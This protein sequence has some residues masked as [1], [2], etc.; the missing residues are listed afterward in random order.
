MPVSERYPYGILKTVIPSGGGWRFPYPDEHSKTLKDPFMRAMGFD[1]LVGKV[2]MF[3]IEAGIKVGDVEYEVAS[4]IKKVS[5]GNDRHPNRTYEPRPEGMPDWRPPI[6][7][8]KEWLIT[9]GRR[10][11]RCVL[12]SDAFARADICA[13]CPQNIE[14]RGPCEPCNE[15]VVFRMQNVRQRPIFKGDEPLKFCRLHNVM[16]GAAVFLDQDFLPAKEPNAPAEC[17]MPNRQQ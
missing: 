10:Q 1:A 3:R 7:R 16:L 12:L 13:T 11:V 9:M 2:R 8:G 6:E 5:P 15:D 14:W 17:W 4:Y